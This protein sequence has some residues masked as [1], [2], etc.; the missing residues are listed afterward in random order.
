MKRLISKGDIYKATGVIRLDDVKD[1]DYLS[2]GDTGMFLFNTSS[3]IVVVK[4]QISSISM[5][6]QMVTFSSISAKE[7]LEVYAE[8]TAEN[9]I[10][11]WMQSSNVWSIAG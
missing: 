6:T 9:I 3:G 8:T 5:S 7:T 11:M 4:G 10:A 2:E 1:L